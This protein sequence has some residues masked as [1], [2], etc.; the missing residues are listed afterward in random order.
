MIRYFKNFHLR[1]IVKN[2]NKKL[3]QDTNTTNDGI[4][5][6]EF[7]GNS[8][9]Q[10][11][12]SFLIE[13]L[14]QLHKS[15]CLAYQDII[16][17]SFFERLKIY[18]Q[19]FLNYGNFSIYRSFLVDGFLLMRT[20]KKT[21]IKTKDIYL[22]TIDK[23][24]TKKDLVKLEIDGIHIGDLIYD[25]FL[26]QNEVP[27]I[28]V[29]DKK[30]LSFL[31]HSLK[32]FLYW[33]EFFSNNKVKA[34]VISHSVY[35]SA[36]PLRI[37]ATKDIISFQCNLHNIYKLSKKNIYAFT[38]FKTYKEDFKNLDKELKSTGLRIADEKI[39][40]RFS[41]KIGVDMP[42]SK[43]SAFHQNFSNKKILS[44]TK[45]KKILI[46]AHD[47][48][49][50][51]HIYGSNDVFP[52]FY[53][54]FQFLKIISDKTDYEWYIKSHRDWFAKTD[55]ILRDFAK[56]NSKFHVIPSDT[57]HFQIVKEGINCV[58]TV[59][60]TIG[61]E[62]AY[63][64]VP[65]INATPDNPHMLYDFNLHAKNMKE[66]EHM[67][68]NFE[69]Y[70]INYN[71]DNIKEFYLM[72]N[73]IRKSDWLLDDINEMI[74]KIGYQNFNKLKFYEKFIENFDN[75]KGARIR[76][77]LSNFLKNDKE[78]YLKNKSFVLDNA[79]RLDLHPDEM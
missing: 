59:Y 77:I 72:H 19:K 37:A 33:Q 14:K 3:F 48:F 18:I 23:I 67:V 53:E 2:F 71:K 35:I 28:N 7:S 50:A 34:L 36:I 42:Y 4:I 10:V 29:K 65:V 25:S 63:F 31:K 73:I 13:K 45:K 57:S 64:G 75:A 46:A 20:S 47:F 78:Y 16:K 61:W 44:D 41:G 38:E 12:F 54:W 58:L 6:C 17:F 21:E 26:R 15:K 79:S 43:K 51:P 49:D 69:K 39:K 30:F 70:E 66:Y 1:K 11:A 22:E 55:R 9:N 56:D 8:S 76:E 5:L 68:L 27:T 24:K 74:G 40:E 60:G 32:C 52:D 62:Y